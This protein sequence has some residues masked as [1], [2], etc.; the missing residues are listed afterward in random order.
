M[1]LAAVQLALCV[2][3]QKDWTKGQMTSEC[4]QGH[5]LFI[6]WR[7]AATHICTHSW[8]LSHTLKEAATEGRRGGRGEGEEGGRETRRT[9]HPS[10]VASCA[11]ARTAWYN[12]SI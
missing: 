4:T 8:L 11:R 1:P 12:C 2:F 9:R 3:P 6:D 7:S 5:V 10:N